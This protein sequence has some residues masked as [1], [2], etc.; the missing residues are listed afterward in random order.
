[1]YRTDYKKYIP[2]ER[3]TTTKLPFVIRLSRLHKF[4]YLQ[5]GPAHLDSSTSFTRPTTVGIFSGVDYNHNTTHSTKTYLKITQHYFHKID[6]TGWIVEW[7]DIY[8]FIWQLWFARTFVGY[9]EDG[10][11]HRNFNTLTSRTGQLL[12]PRIIRFT[13]TQ[14]IPKQSLQMFLS[15]THLEKNFISSIYKCCVGGLFYD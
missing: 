3:S 5:H 10:S 13:H 8:V 11:L 12:L 6:K 7:Y 15:N 14:L 1:M 4:V 2:L 9:N